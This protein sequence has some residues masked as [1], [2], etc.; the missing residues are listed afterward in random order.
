[1]IDRLGMLFMF[2]ICSG[3]PFL[4]FLMANEGSYH[5]LEIFSYDLDS[6]ILAIL[7]FLIFEALGIFWLVL[8]IYQKPLI[9][10][11]R[12]IHFPGIF[13]RNK[14]VPIRNIRTLEWVSGY[15]TGDP[16]QLLHVT[17]KVKIYDI[18]KRGSRRVLVT[19]SDIE[20]LGDILSSVTGKKIE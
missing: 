3:F 6:K 18:G 4:L 14:D 7:I 1:M 13:I 2:F 9:V 11:D 8:L 15:N 16:R 12:A 10:D 5:F 20:K 19:V 17:T